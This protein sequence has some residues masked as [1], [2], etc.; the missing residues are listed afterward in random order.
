M[1]DKAGIAA[2]RIIEECLRDIGFTVM[3]PERLPLIAQLDAYNSALELVFSEG[4]ALHGLQLLGPI[5]AG[6][7]VLTRRPGSRMLEPNLAQRTDRL[8][9]TLLGNHFIHGVEAS[10]KPAVA[11]GLL[12]PE[13]D[14]LAAFLRSASAGGEE[15]A[16]DPERLRGAV[17]ADLAAYLEREAESRRGGVPATRERINAQLERAGFAHLR[18]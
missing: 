2:E 10:G 14:R 17:E 6:I 15:V 16:V 8:S 11:S 3:H 5:R 4:S 18:M 13:A 1:G 7:R 9:Y 12:L